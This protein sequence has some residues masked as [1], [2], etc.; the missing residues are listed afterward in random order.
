MRRRQRWRTYTRIRGQTVGATAYWKGGFDGRR[1]RLDGEGEGAG[2]DH[3]I[4]AFGEQGVVGGVLGHDVEAAILRRG[5]GL[6]RGDADDP[7]VLDGIAELC[8]FARIDAADGGVEAQNAHG[9][10]L[11]AEWVNPDLAARAAQGAES[12][13]GNQQSYR[14]KQLAEPQQHVVNKTPSRGV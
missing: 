10:G 13:K 14:Q 7:G 3:A 5:G 12:P 2:G 1:E 6:H 11:S 8:G 9:S 4:V